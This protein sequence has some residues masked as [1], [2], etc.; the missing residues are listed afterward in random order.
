MISLLDINKALIKVLKESIMNTEFSDVPIIATDE[1]EIIRPS[2][3]LNMEA[4]N[5]EKVNANWVGRTIETNLY[6]F[7]KDLKKYKID[8]LKIQDIIES[9]F[10]EGLRIKENVYVYINDIEVDTVDT[11]LVI[12]FEFDVINELIKIDDSE[13]METLDFELKGEK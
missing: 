7:A 4:K 11:V 6:F 10:I 9:A 5:L 13:Y 3:K 1:T 8:N 12:T 2:L